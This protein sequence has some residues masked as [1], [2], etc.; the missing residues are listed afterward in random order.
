MIKLEN[1]TY[2]Y[3]GQ[4]IINA[5]N[6]E[7]FPGEIVGIIGPASS[8][9]TTLL[10]IISGI[11]HPT[12]G[13]LYINNEKLKQKKRNSSIASLLE[14]IVPYSEDT[15][16]NFLLL[17]RLPLKKFLHSYSHYDKQLIEDLLSSFKL[18]KYSES[19]IGDLSEGILQRLLLAYVFTKETSIV[20]ADNPTD[21]LDLESRVNISRI[22][23]KY[24]MGGDRCFVMASNDLNFIAQTCDR[25]II[26]NE[27]IIV[28]QGGPEIITP[29][30]L[31]KYFSVDVL[32]TKN[33]YNG[34]PEI[35]FFPGN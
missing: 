31:K 9:K 4:K 5:I 19:L 27:G 14:K 33:I 7:I 13:S 11:V 10:K 18:N 2:I 12:E 8:G 28:K 22:L 16:R 34:K 6:A 30:N 32:I 17:G 15:V 35:H 1:I 26:L 23:I 24:V 29:E 20:I 25:L 3:K 21:R